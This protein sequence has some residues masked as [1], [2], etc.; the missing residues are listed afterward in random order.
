MDRVLCI[1]M[2]ISRVSEYVCVCVLGCKDSQ[3]AC[4]KARA[5]AGSEK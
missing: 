3:Q 4:R 5:R 1:V 2:S